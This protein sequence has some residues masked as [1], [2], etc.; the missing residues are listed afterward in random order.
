MTAQE[1]KA[2][3]LDFAIRGKLVLQ[4]PNDEPADRLLERI[5]EVGSRVPRDRKSATRGRAGRATLLPITDDEKPFDLPNGWA[6]CRLGEITPEFSYGT[7]SKSQ[8]VG[9][10][11]VLRMGN[12]Q[13]GEIEY[14]DLV[15]TSDENDIAKYRLEKFDLL[16]NRTNS[17][18][19]VGKVSIYRAKIPAIYAGYLVRFRPEG[20][21][22]EF[23]N[24]VMNSA[25]AYDFC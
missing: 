15:Y 3:I 19:K 13:D 24:Y 11:P 20:V 2:A 12:L 14:S 10:V 18:D 4:D 8:K 5:N 1:L 25:Y 22:L 16:F 9:K 23:V 6:W 21:N 17:A 7:S